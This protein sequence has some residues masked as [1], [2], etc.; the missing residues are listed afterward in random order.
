MGTYYGA[1]QIEK[2]GTKIS[3][4]SS[5]PPTPQGNQALVAVMDNGVFRIAV[6]VSRA[7]EYEHFKDAYNQGN[8]LDMKVFAISKDKL[9]E[10]PDTGRAPS[11]YGQ[12]RG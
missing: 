10:C 9:P 5:T 8:W 2:L 7:S 1:E 3:S 11:T 12:G 4:Y 6:D